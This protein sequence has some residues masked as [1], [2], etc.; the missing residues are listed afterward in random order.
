[1]RAAATTYCRSAEPSSSG[2]VPTAMNLISPCATEAATSVEKVRRFAA[3]LRATRSA[4]PGS[5]RSAAAR[6]LESSSCSVERSVKNG[7]PVRVTEIAPAYEAKGLFAG[8]LAEGPAGDDA[9]GAQILADWTE[10]R[11][12]FWQV[13]PKEMLDRK[14]VV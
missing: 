2:G 7:R 8:R 3:R 10:A 6:S 14:S 11:G 4:R 1:M 12:Q 13:V 5:G 9:L